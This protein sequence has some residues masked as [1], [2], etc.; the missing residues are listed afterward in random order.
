MRI[1]IHLATRFMF[2]WDP[3]PANQIRFIYL[4]LLFVYTSTLNFFNQPKDQPH[5]LVIGHTGPGR[6]L[7]AVQRDFMY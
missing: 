3:P 1:V 7:R 2:L 6:K 4:L 5:D